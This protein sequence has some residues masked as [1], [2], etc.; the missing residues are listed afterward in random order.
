MAMK[1][2]LI[3]AIV[4]LLATLWVALDAGVTAMMLF[5]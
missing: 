5:T 1:N 2:K 3:L 4:I